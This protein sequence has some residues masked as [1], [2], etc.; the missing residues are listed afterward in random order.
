MKN[1][2]NEVQLYGTLMDIQPEEF[3][4]DG[5]KFKRFYV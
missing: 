5:D 2:K 1:N 4:K 3:F